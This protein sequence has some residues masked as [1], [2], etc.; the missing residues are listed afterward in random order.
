[1]YNE[2][3]ALAQRLRIMTSPPNYLHKFLYFSNGL[4]HYETYNCD[5]ADPAY[6]VATL[7]YLVDPIPPC[8][9]LSVGIDEQFVP[10]ISGGSLSQSIY[11]A[12]ANNGVPTTPDILPGTGMTVSVIYD[13]FKFVD[14]ESVAD[15]LL[16]HEFRLVK[17][18]DPA[19][20][21]SY[22]IADQ[23]RPV[24]FP[25]PKVTAITRGA[26]KGVRKPGAGSGDSDIYRVGTVKFLDDTAT[27]FKATNVRI[28]LQ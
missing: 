23:C 4:Y 8:G 9:P 1:V 16:P 12:D 24:V 19:T 28:R 15:A 7:S 2:Q 25:L 26:H 18:L 6:G 17:V 20:N 3:L 5:I 11:F 14:V 22:Y 27:G 21:R 10:S 13:R